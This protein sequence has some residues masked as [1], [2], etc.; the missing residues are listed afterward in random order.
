M[1]TWDT[2]RTWVANEV[3]TAAVMNAAIRDQQVVIGVHA[4]DGSAG[5]GNDELTG[6]DSI[7]FDDIGP[8]TAYQWKR[9]GPHLKWHNGTKVIALTEPDAAAATPSPRTIGPG[10][11]QAAS[12]THTHKSS[13][14]R[15]GAQ[16]SVGG[17]GGTSTQTGTTITSGGTGDISC[18]WETEK[19]TT[20]GSSGNVDISYQ[21]NSV[22]KVTTATVYNSAVNPIRA[23]YT[24]YNQAAGDFTA[25]MVITNNTDAAQTMGH[26]IPSGNETGVVAGGGGHFVGILSEA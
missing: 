20:A 13:F 24:F 18:Y 26:D 19:T 3:P 25:R 12:G 7:A 22:E 4:H 15:T 16:A 10:E 6:L 5:E 21:I 14:D 23:A 1:A 17:A 8:P 9:D 11:F 2:P